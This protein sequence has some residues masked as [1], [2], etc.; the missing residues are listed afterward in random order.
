MANEQGLELVITSFNG[1]YVGYLT[2]NRHFDS[3][4]KDEV[5]T[6]N[7]VGFNGGGMAVEVL[8]RKIALLGNSGGAPH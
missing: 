6:L 7:W 1:R 8:K 4:P 2:D 3:S 5:R